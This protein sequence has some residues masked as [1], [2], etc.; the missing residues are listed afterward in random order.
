MQ[1]DEDLI[2]DLDYGWRQASSAVSSPQNTRQI[3][4]TGD[5]L[6]VWAGHTAVVG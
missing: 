2:D 1:F 3:Q 6:G 4:V 5:G